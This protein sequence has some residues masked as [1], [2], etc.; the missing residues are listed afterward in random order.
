MPPQLTNVSSGI[1]HDAARR[2]LDLS[3]VLSLLKR[4]W[5]MSRQRRQG[6][7]VTL[8]DLNDRELVDIGLTREEI[9]YFTPGRA[10]DRLRDRATDPWG[11]GVI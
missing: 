7:R 1:G 5:R 10:I 6:Q 4:Y 8:Q 3:I 9:D 11:R 2:G